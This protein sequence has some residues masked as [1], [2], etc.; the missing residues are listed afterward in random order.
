MSLRR[1]PGLPRLARAVVASMLGATSLVTGRAVP[2][3]AQWAA[4][5]RT[6]YLAG[7]FNW[8]FRN[9]FPAADRTF[10]AL[11]YVRGRTLERLWRGDSRPP[12]VRDQALS[13]ELA[14]IV[15]R[16]P[17]RFAVPEELAAAEFSRAVPEVQ[18]MLAWARVT[19]RQVLDVLSD[20]RLDV[21]SKEARISELLSSYREQRRLAIGTLPKTAAAGEGQFYSLAFRRA[22]P[23]V[24]ALWWSARWLELST[25]EA[26]VETE[27][28]AFTGMPPGEVRDR[29]AR[30]LAGF[31]QGAP[32]G[33][34]RAPTVAPRFTARY[35]AAAALLDNLGTLESAIADVLV[36]AEVPRSARRL[37]LLRL[38]ARFRN[39]TLDAESFAAWSAP[40]A[41]PVAPDTGR[42]A[43]GH[44]GMSH[45]AADTASRGTTQEATDAGHGG[46][47]MQALMAMHRR[48]L[49]DPVI[50]ERI[51]T[52]P[53]LQRM[54]SAMGGMEG[55]GGMG[56]TGEA[57][58]MPGMKS[59]DAPAAA[60]RRRA[61]EFIVRLLSDP[62]VE[63]R[64][65]GDPRIA[66]LRD[67]PQVQRA[68]EALRKASGA[69]VPTDDAPRRPA[70]P[71]RPP[72]P[73]SHQHPVP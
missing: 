41:A 9:H 17:P 70:A 26:L 8:E 57:E 67:D 68:L 29:L 44:A 33:M 51:A 46:M 52:D 63:S 47:T 7:S 49:A 20:G 34:P 60:T 39:D 56:M 71:T 73:S 55:M 25:V 5:S 4:P 19:R 48:M 45:G 23:R 40:A 50:R 10:Q 27:G 38:A 30:M 42:L 2:A 32:Q 1:A 37:E 69:A 61:A 3:R 15:L 43:T 53:V 12:A 65:N 24:H 62:T 6:T 58:S 28:S 35:P 64:I 31:P 72:A 54:V 59:M 18:A 16:S 11:S 13:D 36:S 66:R 21:A 22:F 14:R